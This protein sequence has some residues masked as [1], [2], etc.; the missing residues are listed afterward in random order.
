MG[1]SE[2]GDNLNIFFGTSAPRSPAYLI[3]NNQWPASR[4][5]IVVTPQLKRDLS[6]PN[7]NDQEWPMRTVDEVVEYIRANFKVDPS[8][9]YLT[10]ISL[11]GAACWNYA[12]RY[13]SKVAAIVPMSGKTDLLKADS[14]KNIPIWVFHGSNDALVF[15]THSINMVD[16]ILH[17]PS[18]GLYKPHLNLLYARGHEGWNEIY[19]GENGY[20][21]YSWLMQF[22]KGD[23]TNKPPYVNAGIDQ[24]ILVTPSVHLPVE[25]FDSDGSIAYV[26]WT[27]T[28]GSSLTLT[29]EDKSLK[30]S[31]ITAAGTYE[32]QLTVTDDDGVSASD[33]VILEVLASVP[34]GVPAIAETYLTDINEVRLAN[35][36]EGMTINTI[37]SGTNINIEATVNGSPKFIRFRI[38]S[39]QSTRSPG[40]APYYINKAFWGIENGTFII[41]ATPYYRFNNKDTPGVSRFYQVTFTNQDTSLKN[42]YAKANSNISQLSSWGSNTDG[43]GAAPASFSASYQIFNVNGAALL[44][45]PLTVVGTQSKLVI[46]S[47]GQLTINSMLGSPIEVNG[48]GTVI[49]NQNQPITFS[50][51]S[52]TSSITFDQNASVIPSAVYGNVRLKGA[53]TTK[54]L[55]PGNLTV[56]GNLII[57]DRVIL[58]GASDHSSV[59]RVGGTLSVQEKSNFA[60]SEKFSVEFTGTGTQTLNVSASQIEL[61]QILVHD[62]VTVD[63][64]GPASG[65]SILCGHSGGGG[66]V[67]NSGSTIK[68]HQHHLIIQGS[69]ALNGANQNGKLSFQ[70]GLLTLSGN[71][72]IHSHLNLVT[73]ED[74]V[75]VLTT[76]LTGTGSLYLH[77]TTYIYD[78]VKVSSGTIH[79]GSF[80]T[81]TASPGHTARVG[82]VG[83]AGSIEGN[84]KV[85]TIF[86]AGKQYRYLSFPVNGFKVSD[87]QAFMPVTGN[88]TGASTVTGIGKSPS[89]FY[90][91]EP[92][93]GWLAYPKTSNTQ[94]LVLGTGYA[95]YS[96]DPLAMIKITAAGTLKTGNHAYTLT[97]DP[98][99]STPDNGWNLLGN[100]YASPIQWGTSGWTRSGVNGTTWI[101]DNGVPGGRFLVWDGETG[102][103]EFQGIIPEG[104]SFWVNVTSTSPTLIITENAKVNSTTPSI[105]R[106]NELSKQHFSISLQRRGLVDRAFIKLNDMASDAFDENVDALKKENG[107][108]NIATHSSDHVSLAINNVARLFCEKKI[109]LSAKMDTLGT[110][111]LVVDGPAVQESMVRITL[112]D[113]FIDSTV[114]LS[115][116]TPY[117]FIVTADTLSK[118]SRRFAIEMENMSLPQPIISSE[119][120]TLN[121]SVQNGNQ[122]LYNGT[123]IPGATGPT[124]KAEDSGMYQVKVSYAYCEKISEPVSFRVTG[125]DNLS[126][127]AIQVYPNPASHQLNVRGLMGTQ[128][129]YEI[130]TSTGNIVMTG[131]I[132]EGEESA[133]IHLDNISS[134]MYILQLKQ[135]DKIHR[136]KIFVQ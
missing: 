109:S 57:D 131:N 23:N 106:E 85:Q 133:T 72:N 113:S 101:R 50:S 81:L 123:P 31:G 56:N 94:T 25:Y 118:G 97:P 29:P 73:N 36:S 99:T 134:G 21:I 84:V 122:W 41:C 126:E 64:A 40:T 35:L 119:G 62:N 44:N 74:T 98:N 34:N 80:L 59:L 92:G 27:Q 110:Y 75:R 114:H 88:F 13:S 65:V 15:P 82:R 54:T 38:N 100:P 52:S 48:N 93:G 22:S 96:F 111:A 136:Y 130:I 128:W 42:F 69:G 104:Q 103:M 132:Q 33:K 89:L 115:P 70:K 91:N 125:L 116:G 68:L 2:I 37:T 51:V 14:V 53:N 8:R 55:P 20:D 43:T 61:K 112:I 105:F 24:K 102:D 58:N 10:G 45:N 66:V 32:F 67:L 71:S 12:A 121:S 60:P 127:R 4:P 18:P 129:N 1:G 86:G 77:N 117:E 47:T 135:L 108:F 9:I 120:N 11:G 30:V 28:A 95:V 87:L 63:V 90:Y 19:T 39:N 17:L 7:F 46:N 76:N 124:Y 107:Y 5:F 79:S 3:H 78:S 83:S 6:I 16:S 26:T 49:L